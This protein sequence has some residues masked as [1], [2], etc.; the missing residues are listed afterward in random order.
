MARSGH[1]RS[2]KVVKIST[3]RQP[4]G[5]FLS[6]VNN[7]LGHILYRF[8]DIWTKILEIA[9]LATPVWF[10]GPVWSDSDPWELP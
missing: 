3:I 10:E 1:S 9:V 2:I 6:V 5:D 7:N 8:R 4:I